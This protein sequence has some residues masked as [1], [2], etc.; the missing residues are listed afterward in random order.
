MDI[1]QF[2]RYTGKSVAEIR[3]MMGIST[4][5]I[6]NET[7]SRKA[8]RDLSRKRGRGVDAAAIAGRL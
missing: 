2:L 7:V 3:S 1:A 4:A 6:N 5:V 8:Y